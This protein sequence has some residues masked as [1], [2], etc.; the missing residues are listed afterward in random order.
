M[1]N[2]KTLRVVRL[3]TEGNTALFIRDKELIYTTVA[4][5]RMFNEFGPHLYLTSNEKI[6][7]GDWYYLET[8]GHGSPTGVYKSTTELTSKLNT[9]SVNCSKIIATTDKSLT[10]PK[11]TNIGMQEECGGILQV[12]ALPQIP[13]PFVEAYI[14]AEGKIDEVQV[15]MKQYGTPEDPITFRVKLDEFNAVTIIRRW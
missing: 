6:K 9:L 8:T 13:Q 11:I 12:K 3:P 10:I 14:K 4:L 2:R 7:K 15:E 1:K 5:R